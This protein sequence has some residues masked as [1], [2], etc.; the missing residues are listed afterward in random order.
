[1]IGA[2]G[3]LGVDFRLLYGEHKRIVELA[4]KSWLPAM[5]IAREFVEDSCLICFDAPPRMS[6][7]SSR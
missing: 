6:T 5:Y 1:M 3:W 2:L 4:A 7:R